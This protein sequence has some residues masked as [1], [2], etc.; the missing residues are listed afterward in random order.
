M[1]MAVEI[2]LYPL[3]ERYIR[4]AGLRVQFIGPYRLADG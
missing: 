4:H 2:S 1:D 3:D